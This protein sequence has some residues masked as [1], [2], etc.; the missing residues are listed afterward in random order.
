[1]RYQ[2]VSGEEEDGGYIEEGG[3]AGMGFELG[4]TYGQQR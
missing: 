4:I 1:M 3:K 2:V